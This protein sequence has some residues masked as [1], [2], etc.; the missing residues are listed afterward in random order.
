[1]KK[2]C[3]NVK[4]LNIFSFVQKSN[5]VCIRKSWE[6]MKV[7][8]KEFDMLIKRCYSCID[9]ADQCEFSSCDSCGHADDATNDNTVLLSIVIKTWF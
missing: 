8:P 2:K 4:M 9:L 1:M 3:K 6:I 5:K 7:I